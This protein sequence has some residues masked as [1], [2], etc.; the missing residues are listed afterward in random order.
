MLALPA[1]YGAGS[2][3]RTMGL[4]TGTYGMKSL[5][6]GEA[7]RTL[8]EIGYDGVE[9]ALMPGWPTD[10]AILSA[11]DR[12]EVRRILDGTGLAVPS[13]MESL[14]MD[15]TAKTKEHHR[16]RLKLGIELAHQLSPGHLPVIETVIGGKTAEW[17]LVKSSMADELGDW[18]KLAEEGGIT[19]CFKP[20]ADQAVDMPDRA[21][22]ML[23]QVPSPRIRIVYDYSHYEVQKLSLAGS[24]RP[25]LPYTSYIAVKDAAGDRNKHQFLLPGDGDIDYVAYFRLLKELGYQRVCGDR[26]HLADSFEAGIRTSADRQAVLRAGGAGDGESGRAASELEGGTLKKAT[27]SHVVTMRT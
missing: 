20:H 4:N 9:I 12:Q 19:I 7:L 5:K 11:G 22:W 15:G 1:V 27:A 23:K 14:S 18:A 8:A 17:D 21:I 24:L 3:G 2:A 13:L 16:E 25:L 6:I 26:D 10:P